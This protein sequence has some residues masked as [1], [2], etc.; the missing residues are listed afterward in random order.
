MT[1]VKPGSLKAWVLAARPKTLSGAL[2]PVMLATAL[3]YSDGC[4]DWVNALLCA[5]FACGM[6][7]AA[8]FINDWWD[9]RKGSDGADR[10]G[11]E[12]ACA[13]GWIKP[14][15]MVRGILVTVALSCLAFGLPVVLRSCGNMVCG[16]WEIVAAGVASVVFAFVYTLWFSY[17]GLGDL[18]VLLFFGL[19]PVCG[20]YYVQ[21]FTLTGD[22]FILSAISGVA[23][24]A[25]LFINNY[26]DRDQD[27]ENG[28]QTLIVRWGEPFGRWG[29]LAIGIIVTLL[30]AW[31]AVRRELPEVAFFF[32]I[33]VYL[34]LHIRTWR[35][36]CDMRHG[37]QL[38]ILLGETSRNMLLLGI[39]LS[40]AL[41]NF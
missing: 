21:A 12:R 27:R 23:I 19:V 33:V 18:L 14:G 2:I 6:Q 25:L 7:V 16:G 5:L 36:L 37:R 3:A 40:L 41:I 9:Y 15:A 8:N 29:Y 11:P 13:Q 35:R 32:G 34:A 22:T 17:W 1:E 30:G 4:F 38:N 10:L 31:L 20:T 39:L 24:D 26:R 28:K